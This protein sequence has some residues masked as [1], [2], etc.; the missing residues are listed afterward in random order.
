MKLPG[1]IPAELISIN[2]YGEHRWKATTILSMGIGQGEILVTPLADG[3]YDF[4]HS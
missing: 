2:F 1:F 4:S 3:K